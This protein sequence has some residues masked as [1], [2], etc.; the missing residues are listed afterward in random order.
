MFAE[1]ATWFQHLFL[2]ASALL[3][4]SPIATTTPSTVDNNPITP[5]EISQSLHNKITDLRTEVERTHLDA[6]VPLSRPLSLGMKG[7]DVLA[8]QTLML[9]LHLITP[10]LVTGFYG[11]STQAAVANFQKAY[12]LTA[13]GTVDR[14]TL[15]ELFALDLHDLH[16]E[17]IYFPEEDELLAAATSS[18]ALIDEYNAEPVDTGATEDASA[19]APSGYS[20]VT[21][22]YTLTASNYSFFPATITA[23]K[24]DTVKIHII[25]SGTHSFVIDAYKVNTGSISNG[26]TADISFVASSTGNFQFYSSQST[27]KSKGMTGTLTV[28]Q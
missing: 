10:D 8:L 18:R 25:S 27:D 28:S 4:L 5:E 15:D 1:L 9:S 12:L 6:Q 2:G 17:Q 16:L 14:A 20:P 11:S 7:D 24:G 13:S 3:A 23:S 19:P 21:R 22:S 26:K